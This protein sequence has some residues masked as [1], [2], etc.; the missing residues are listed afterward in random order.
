MDVFE[1]WYF[2]MYFEVEGRMLHVVSVFF[3]PGILSFGFDHHVEYLLV[4][5]KGSRR[6]SEWYFWLGYLLS[7]FP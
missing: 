5:Q 3:S 7:Y 1:T 2:G 4:V 6:D